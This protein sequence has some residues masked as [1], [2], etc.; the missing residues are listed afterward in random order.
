[1]RALAS[2]ELNLMIISPDILK[3]ILHILKMLLSH[4]LD[5]NYVK[6]LKRTYGLIMEQ[7]N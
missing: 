6:T 7:L 5:L 2:Q 3:N 1:M 4:M